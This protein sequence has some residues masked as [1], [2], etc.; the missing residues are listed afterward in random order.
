MNSYNLKA[1]KKKKS[2]LKMSRRTEQT[3]KKKTSLLSTQK[4]AQYR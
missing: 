1:K 3:L 2:D 4:D